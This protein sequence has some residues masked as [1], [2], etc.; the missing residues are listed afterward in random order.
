ML[1]LCIAR[2]NQDSLEWTRA[3]SAGKQLVKDLRRALAVLEGSGSLE[4]ARE[5]FHIMDRINPGRFDTVFRSLMG[6][7][8]DQADRYSHQA[9]PRDVADILHG[10]LKRPD[11]CGKLLDEREEL[12]LRLQTVRFAYGGS[13]PSMLKLKKL[14]CES[15]DA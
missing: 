7:S 5:Y 11:V 14:I 15:V 12:E 8:V 9:D 6:L 10:F 13:D 3:L 4:E 1:T 2:G